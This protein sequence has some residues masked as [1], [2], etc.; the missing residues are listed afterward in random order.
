MTAKCLGII[1]NIHL[2][3]RYTFNKRYIKKLKL[4]Q[5][6]VKYVSPMKIVN[7]NLYLYPKQEKEDL[8]NKDH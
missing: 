2:D 5:K 1:P 7:C 3:C 4:N 6:P 8:L